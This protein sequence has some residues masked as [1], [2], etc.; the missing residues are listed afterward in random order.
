MKVPWGARL[1]SVPDVV[2]AGPPGVR[3]VVPMGKPEGSGVNVKPAAE[4]M[5]GVAGGIGVVVVGRARVVGGPEG[6]RAR[7]PA[8]EGRAV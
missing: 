4:K 6:G 5:E 3:E 8:L 2:R 7:M 1:M